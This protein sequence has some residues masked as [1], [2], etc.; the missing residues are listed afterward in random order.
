MSQ[1]LVGNEMLHT[2]PSILEV[3]VTLPVGVPLPGASTLTVKSTV[4]GFPRVEFVDKLVVIVV[5][6][7]ALST[8]WASLPEVLLL[9]LLS[10]AYEAWIVFA[11]ADVSIISQVPTATVATQLFVPSVTATLPVGVPPDPVTVKTTV[12][13]SPTTEGSGS[14][15]VIVVVVLVLLVAVSVGFG[16]FVA[17]I[18]GVM[19]GTLGTNRASPV[20]MIVLL[21]KQFAN[22][23]CETVV[24]KA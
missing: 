22:C 21:P 20:L 7:S 6:V 8:V 2:S 1:V 5:V 19:V 9:K 12:T 4:T 13:V 16:V 17:V 10:P 3:I 11:P 23:S 18:L 15:E 24:L 14:A